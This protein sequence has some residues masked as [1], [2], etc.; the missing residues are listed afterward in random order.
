MNG[1]AK[2]GLVVG[3][4]AA[5]VVAGYAASWSHDRW[6]SAQPYDTSGGMY[7]AGVAMTGLGAFLIVALV[8]T[9]MALWFLRR[10]KIVWNVIALL[11]L[12]F[13]VVGLL[14]V[15]VMMGTRSTP[16]S[17]ALMALDLIGLAQLLGVPLWTAASCCSPSWHR[18]GNRGGC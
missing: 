16:H 12:G 7:A 8:P 9:L 1:W 14:G 13:A 6:L 5:A 17:V 10:N 2:T 3:G 18:P 4:Y 11:A 15:A